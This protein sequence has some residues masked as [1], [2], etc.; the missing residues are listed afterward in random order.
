MPT[1]LPGSGIAELQQ[2]VADVMHFEV[3]CGRISS[4]TVTRILGF[5]WWKNEMLVHW[6]CSLQEDYV[7]HIERTDRVYCPC[8]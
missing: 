3:E 7:V 1:L 2:I 4:I 8:N 6:A 5:T